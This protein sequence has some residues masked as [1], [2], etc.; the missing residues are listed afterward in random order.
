MLHRPFSTILTLLCL[1]IGCGSPSTPVVSSSKAKASP[2]P[3]VWCDTLNQ[4]LRGL[5]KS[6]FHCLEL[7]NFLITGFFGPKSNPERS[8]FANA[9]FAGDDD[10]AERLR[11]SVRPAGDLRF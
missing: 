1:F 3:A 10:A 9:C 4:A 8:D 7:P 6:G 2:P 11:I 5:G